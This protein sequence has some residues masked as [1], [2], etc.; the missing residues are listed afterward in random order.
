[1]TSFK[2]KADSTREFLMSCVYGTLAGTLVGAATLAFSDKPGDN[3]GNIARGASIG[4][5]AG[6]ILGAYIVY[7]VPAEDSN[8]N[9]ETPIENEKKEELPI[10]ESAMRTI[11]YPIITQQN[12]IDGIGVLYRLSSF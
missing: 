2:V 10:E 11:I 6:M 3:L 1:M 4:L 12:K 5:Y 7:L 8:T 9:P